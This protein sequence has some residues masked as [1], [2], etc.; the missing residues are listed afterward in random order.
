MSHSDQSR[1]RISARTGPRQ[2]PLASKGTSGM[3]FPATRVLRAR[4]YRCSGEQASWGVR[5]STDL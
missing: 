5:L 3:S 4:P 1:L 2:Q